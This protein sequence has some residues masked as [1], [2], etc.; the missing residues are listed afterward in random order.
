MVFVHQ[1]IQLIGHWSQTIVLLGP[2]DFSKKFAGQVSLNN[3]EGLYEE[4]NLLDPSQKSLVLLESEITPDLAEELLMREKDPTIFLTSEVIEKLAKNCDGACQQKKS[5]TLQEID[6]ARVKSDQYYEKEEETINY[7]IASLDQVLN[8]RYVTIITNA[9]LSI[10]STK[11]N[12]C[13]VFQF[14]SVLA[15]FVKNSCLPINV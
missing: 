5:E 6:I 8:H 15:F 13:F 11:M 1:L 14:D 3:D 4:F 2:R 9:A 7:Q 12:V 10:I